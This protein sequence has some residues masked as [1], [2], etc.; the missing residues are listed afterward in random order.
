MTQKAAKGDTQAQ[1]DLAEKYTQYGETE[2]ARKLYRQ[3]ANNGHPAAQTEI[4]RTL[5]RKR[6][7]VFQQYNK[8]ALTLF[9]NAVQ[10]NYAPAEMLLGKFIWD[11]VVFQNCM[12]KVR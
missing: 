6:E 12:Q 2:I 8:A 10:E 3:A 1:F 9:N 4:A 5:V 7:H 11:F